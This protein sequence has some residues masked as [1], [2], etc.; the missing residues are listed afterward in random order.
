[1]SIELDKTPFWKHFIFSSK[2]YVVDA[3]WKRLFKTFP[4]EYLQH[5]QS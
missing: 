2:T 5:M 1:M 4:N 3:H